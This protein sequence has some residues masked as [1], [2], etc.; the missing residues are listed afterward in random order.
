M[1]RI[2]N[3]DRSIFAIYLYNYRMGFIFVSKRTW[4]FL[5]NNVKF[6]NRL[7]DNSDFKYAIGK[8]D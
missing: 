2:F 5:D 4:E 6:V 8:K 3:Y 7:T 1:K